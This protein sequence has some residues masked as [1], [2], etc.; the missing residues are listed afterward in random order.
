MRLTW[1]IARSIPLT[2]KEYKHYTFQGDEVLVVEGLF[3]ALDE[4]LGFRAHFKSVASFGFFRISNSTLQLLRQF[5]VVRI[6]IGHGRHWNWALCSMVCLVGC[7]KEEE[8]EMGEHPP[9]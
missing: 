3:L 8:R 7:E 4:L 9:F 1:V 6:S 2:A 5:S